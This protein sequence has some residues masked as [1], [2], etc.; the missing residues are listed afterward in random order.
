MALL[1]YLQGQRTHCL[2]RSPFPLLDSFHCHSQPPPT[3]PSS[4]VLSNARYHS[5]SGIRRHL[6]SSLSPPGY[7]CSLLAV[8]HRIPQES[9]DTCPVHYLLQVTHAHFWLYAIGSLRNQKTPAQF[10]TSSRLHMHT[11][12]C[13]SHYLLQVTH[14]HFWLYV[15]GFF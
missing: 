15:I 10:T 8:C 9:E 11:S 3:D 2:K 13:M 14:A 7:T 5:P 6:P 12:G 4:A 1:A